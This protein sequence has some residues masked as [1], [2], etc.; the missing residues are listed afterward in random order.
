MKLFSKLCGL[1]LSLATCGL[2]VHAQDNTP[3]TILHVSMKPVQIKAERDWEND[4][5]RY[6]YNQ[7]KYYVTTILPYLNEAVAMHQEMQKRTSDPDWSKRKKKHYL[8]AKEDELRAKFDEEI[9]NLN[10]TQGVLLVKLISRQTGENIYH[11]L[12]DYKSA[13]TAT[14]WLGWAAVHGFNLNKQYDPANEPMLENIME[15][16]DYPLPELYYNNQNL[17]VN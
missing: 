12:L 14:K 3:D 7:T 16:L 4:T 17:T 10:E 1:T 9:K 8:K 15:S 6:H 11:M 5:V 13:I 2:I